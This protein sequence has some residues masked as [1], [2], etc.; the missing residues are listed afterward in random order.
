MFRCA[1][2][3]G[4]G[5]RGVNFMMMIPMILFFMLFV[6]L[7]LKLLNSKNLILSDSIASHSKALDILNERF[8]SGEISE[9][10]YKSKKKIILDK[11]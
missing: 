6:Y 4:F 1:S 11:I 10:E 8:A 5:F 9:E 7:F 3:S 2:I